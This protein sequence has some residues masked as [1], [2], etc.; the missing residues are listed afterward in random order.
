MIEV[1]MGNGITELVP[2]K[3]F[4]RDVKEVFLVL[5]VVM[6]IIF[7]FMFIWHMMRHPAFCVVY[8]LISYGWLALFTYA[9]CRT[10]RKDRS[11][12]RHSRS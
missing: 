7:G 11:A 9:N 12:G 5:S 1:D 3:R 8:W 4:L 10:K 6:P 2:L